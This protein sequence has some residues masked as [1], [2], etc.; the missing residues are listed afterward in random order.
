MVKGLLVLKRGACFRCVNDVGETDG[1]ASEEARRR[2]IGDID[3][4]IDGPF[5]SIMADM[6]A[7]R[8]RGG[9]SRQ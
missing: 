5:L 3:G 1:M 7:F 4:P 8:C 2:L 9:F 6:C